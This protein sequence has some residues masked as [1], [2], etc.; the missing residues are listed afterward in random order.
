MVIITILSV[1]IGIVIG[2]VLAKK[3]ERYDILLDTSIS[4][5]LNELPPI[6]AKAHRSIKIATDL[7]ARFFNDQRVKEAIENAVGNGAKVMFLSEGEPP[8]WYKDKKDKG[9]IDIKLV[10]KLPRHTMVIDEYHSRVERPHVPL[11]FGGHK[12]DVAILLKGFP[13]LGE[14]LSLEFDDLWASS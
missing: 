14:Q 1:G 8:P 12:D 5:K 9:D 4:D 3:A 10:E 13:K 11:T 6:Y 7:D 2:I